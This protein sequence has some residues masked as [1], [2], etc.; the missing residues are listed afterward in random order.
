MQKRKGKSVKKNK[1]NKE[2]KG[3][4]HIEGCESWIFKSRSNVKIC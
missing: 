1:R 4:Q 3:D 2:V